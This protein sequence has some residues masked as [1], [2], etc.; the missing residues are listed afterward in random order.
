LPSTGHHIYD[1]FWSGSCWLQP[2]EIKML[3]DILT[4]VILANWCHTTCRDMPSLGKP[5][6]QMSTSSNTPTHQLAGGLSSPPC[7]TRPVC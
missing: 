2:D 4:T 6:T 1:G 7:G 5:L 3:A